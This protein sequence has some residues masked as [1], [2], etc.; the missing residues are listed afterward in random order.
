M[1]L[2]EATNKAETKVNSLNKAL[3]QYECNKFNIN[4]GKRYDKMKEALVEHYVKE[5]TEE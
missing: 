1:S 5:F 3:I 4:V 2:E